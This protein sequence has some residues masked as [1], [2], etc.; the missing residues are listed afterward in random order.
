MELLHATKITIGVADFD[1]IE[2]ENAT[3]KS[4]PKI[5]EHI[6]STNP[7]PNERVIVGREFEVKAV[8]AAASLTNMTT[9]FG[10]T[11]AHVENQDIAVLAEHTIALTIQTTTDDAYKSVTVTAM[12]IIPEYEMAF[13]LG[14]RYY[15]PITAKSSETTTM[16]IAVVA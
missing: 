11:G 12:N 16:T 5:I 2:G 6:L 10:G 9:F 4:T 14:E 8:M 15:L 13:K 1:L 7:N 3:V